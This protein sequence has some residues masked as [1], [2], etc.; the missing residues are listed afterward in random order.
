VDHHDLVIPASVER[1]AQVRSIEE[2]EQH[3]DSLTRQVNE[4]KRLVS[5]HDQRFDTLQT[6]W[7]KRV[8]F[9]LQ[10]WPWYD[11][12]GVQKRRPWSR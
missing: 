9:W 4:L 6:P 5:D 2:A 7:W 3:I 11:L 10:G 8:W 1:I 12:N